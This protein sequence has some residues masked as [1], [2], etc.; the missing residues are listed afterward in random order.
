MQKV[1]QSMLAPAIVESRTIATGID[2]TT[3]HA[4]NKWEARATLKLPTDARVLLFSACGIKQNRWKD[5]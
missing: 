3:F 2:R 1:E 5:Y 4:V